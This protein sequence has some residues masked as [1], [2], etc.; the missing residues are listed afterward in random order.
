MQPLPILQWKWEHLPMDFVVGLPRSRRDNDALWVVLDHSR[1][2]E[3]ILR[4]EF[5]E[6]DFHFPQRPALD[7]LGSIS[8]V[9]SISY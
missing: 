5:V 2:W 8:D 4:I 7:L 9:F 3:V 1:S 6:W